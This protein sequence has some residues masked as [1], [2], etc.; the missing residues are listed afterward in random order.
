MFGVA[1][2]ISQTP[3]QNF[4]IVCVEVQVIFLFCQSSLH[5]VAMK[6]C[7]A[8]FK[9]RSRKRLLLW[10]IT[11]LTIL[12]LAVIGALVFFSLNAR[13]LDGCLFN[14]DAMTSP[15]HDLETTV[16]LAAAGIH[17]GEEPTKRVESHTTSTLTNNAVVKT[18]HVTFAITNSPAPPSSSNAARTILLDDKSTPSYRPTGVDFNTTRKHRVYLKE[19]TTIKGKVYLKSKLP[20]RFPSSSWLTVEFRDSRFMDAP[21]I[22]IGKTVLELSNRRR[23]KVF[24]YAI[25]CKK[26]ELPRGSYSVSAVLNIGWKPKHKMEW[27]R[28]GDF[29][30]DT[31]FN[32]KVS[33]FKKI[34]FRNVYLVKYM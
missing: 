28:R 9:V 10:I 24:S 6:R 27:I 1:A 12:S 8:D 34:Y 17:R 21:S 7:I 20:K 16:A 29:F 32:V 11:L 14:E 23:S 3:L 31:H 25:I 18:E 4:S 13:C 2:A 15:S 5:A 22:L 26:R 33:K 19:Y 30:T